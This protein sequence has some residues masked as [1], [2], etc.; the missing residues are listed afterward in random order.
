MIV[1][2]ILEFFADVSW[3]F[4]VIALILTIIICPEKFI[5][6]IEKLRLSKVTKE[7]IEFQKIEQLEEKIDILKKDRGYNF[8]IYIEAQKAI[9]SLKSILDQFG[10]H[11]P[12]EFLNDKFQKSLDELVKNDIL[13]KTIVNEINEVFPYSEEFDRN[14]S[15]DNS[16][17][18]STMA[19]CNNVYKKLEQLKDD[20]HKKDLKLKNKLNERLDEKSISFQNFIDNLDDLIDKLMDIIQYENKWAREI[21]LTSGISDF[22]KDPNFKIV[23]EIILGKMILEGN[24]LSFIIKWREIFNQVQLFNQSALKKIEQMNLQKENDKI[25]SIKAKLDSYHTKL[26]LT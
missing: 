14:K 3:Q 6:F 13:T 2:N 11:I 22:E 16:Y 12:D 1:M 10:I 20:L 4:I 18:L 15:I 8:R 25:A 21:L 26:N 24:E 17:F 23:K 19:K 5:S 9:D 7:G